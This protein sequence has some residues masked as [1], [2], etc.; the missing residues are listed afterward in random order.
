[1]REIDHVVTAKVSY[2]ET[3]KENLNLAA[4][5][6]MF[7]ALSTAPAKNDKLDDQ[8]GDEDDLADQSFQNPD[9]QVG[10][11]STPF[12]PSVPVSKE[13]R[14]AFERGE[15]RTG[16]AAPSLSATRDKRNK[17]TGR[18]PSSSGSM[19]RPPTR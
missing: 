10:G 7:S 3:N 4:A 9:Y 14:S 13:A 11:S 2:P 16:P 18:L 15:T 8:G 17:T 12:T 5:A 1:G 6:N 19:N